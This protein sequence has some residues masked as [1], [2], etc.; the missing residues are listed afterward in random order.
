[1]NVYKLFPTTVIEFDLRGYPNKDKLIDY[2][3]LSPQ[4]N[5]KAVFKG[6]SSYGCKDILLDPQFNLLKNKIQNYIDTYT[7]YLKIQKCYISD[8]WFNI[9]GKDSFVKKHNHE[10]SIVSGAYYPLLESNTC[11]L[12]FTTPLYSSVNFHSIQDNENHHKTFQM[13]IKQDYLYLFPG[14]LDHETEVNKGGKRIV[15]SFN[16]LFTPNMDF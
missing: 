3:N 11:N 7:N 1:M 16:T 9:M 4:K 2:I 5:H 15:L 14:W 8:S 12:I 10:Y 6:K 13:P